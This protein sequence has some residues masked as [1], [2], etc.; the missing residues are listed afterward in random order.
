MASE[1]R[2]N[3]SN[4]LIW[5]ITRSQNAFLVKRKSG[6]GSQFSR[7]PLNLVNKNSRKYA[8]FVNSKAIGVQAAVNGG[9][10]VT[11]KKGGNQ[12]RP[13]PNANTTTYNPT[14]SNRKI[15]KGVAN[16]SVRNAY[17][18]DLRGEAVSRASAL[19]LSQR[20]KRDTPEKKLRGAKARKAAEKE[21]S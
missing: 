10:I 12:N 5:E 17:R 19:R 4:D 15:Y 16:T 3:V 21:S 2:L 7:D 11:T 6:G 1:G 20:P 13:G 14:T 8:G 18:A 9:I